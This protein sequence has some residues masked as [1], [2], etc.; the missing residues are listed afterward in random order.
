MELGGALHCNIHV[1]TAPQMDAAS[2]WDERHLTPRGAGH[3]LFLAV[4]RNEQMKMLTG[5]SWEIRLGQR[6]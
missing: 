6:Q 4:S 2:S 3:A 5:S 1:Q